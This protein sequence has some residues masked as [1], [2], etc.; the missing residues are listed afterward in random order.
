MAS[1]QHSQC[2]L[3]NTLGE[4]RMTLSRDPNGILKVRL[5][6]IDIV[7]SL[8]QQ[9]AK[10]YGNRVLP[11]GRRHT[12]RINKKVNVQEYY[13]LGQNIGTSSILELI[14]LL[15]QRD[16]P[17]IAIFDGSKDGAVGPIFVPEG[18]LPKKPKVV[19]PDIA[20]DI[21]SQFPD[22]KKLQG[23]VKQTEGDLLERQVYDALQTHFK[24]R[25]KEDVLIVQGLEM[26][27]LGGE[28]GRNVHEID[29]LVI[30]FTYQYILNI[31]VK[32]WLG[33]IQGKPE[34][35]TDKAGEQLE[36]NKELFE[37]W[38]GADLKGK[39]RYFSALFCL[40]MEQLLKDCI[41]CKDFIATSQPELL[42]ILDLVEK[43]K[44]QYF[45]LKYYSNFTFIFSYVV[46]QPL[47]STL[48]TSSLSANTSCF[49]PQKSLYQWLETWL[50]L[51]TRLSRKPALLRT[52]K[53]GATPPPR[54][55][56]YSTVAS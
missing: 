9:M 26:V 41:H 28:R 54:K 48:K 46:V 55:G 18:Y 3:C 47:R 7:A 11:S 4:E 38:F 49:W 17:E 24:S 2:P 32:K 34:N 33:Q 36:S 13:I 20:Q 10:C 35:I 6:T 12:N 51:S 29:F 40:D 23:D 37:D 50:V 53:F 56:S 42:I 5:E 14:E 52:S 8:K 21:K 16:Y 45:F 1:H 30:N 43:V 44:L 15:L 25:K 27:K 22:D 19:D 31:E 39:W